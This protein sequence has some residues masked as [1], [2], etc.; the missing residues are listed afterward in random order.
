MDFCPSWLVT[1]SY[2]SG[3]MTVW[4]QNICFYRGIGFLRYSKAREG[5]GES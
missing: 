2:I 4:Q 5:Q 3:G 1:G